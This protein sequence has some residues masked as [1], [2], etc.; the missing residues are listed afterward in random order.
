M[1]VEAARPSWSGDGRPSLLIADDDAVVC[2]ALRIQLEGNFH[3][4]GI[5]NDATEAILLAEKYRPDAA[6]LDVE[7]PNGGARVAVPAIDTRSPDTCVVILSGDECFPVVIELLCAGAIAY[8][9][10]GCTNQHLTK[11]L[12]DALRVKG[13]NPTP[14]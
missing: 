5:A 1:N 6:L 11:T 13:N 8:V 10:K 7:M 3:I 2:S 9:R 12:A 4:V 14:V